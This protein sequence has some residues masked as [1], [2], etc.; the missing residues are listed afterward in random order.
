M[1]NNTQIKIK[2]TINWAYLTQP[3]DLS[4]KYQVD[5]CELS[6]KAV[7][8]LEDM[9]I[10]VRAKEDRGHYVTCKSTR[11]IFAFDKDTGDDIS[12]LGIGNGSEG[13]AVITP[14]E[15]KFKNKSGVS[16][17]LRK[18]VITNHVPMLE[19]AGEADVINDDEV[20]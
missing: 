1:T 11:P 4:D 15:W 16:P 6:D 9:G 14:Y 13:I 17:S 12:G 20:L 2:A 18:L 10:E 3:N 5:L 19:D 7:A 8:A